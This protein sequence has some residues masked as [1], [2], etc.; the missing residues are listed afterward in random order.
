[1]SPSIIRLGGDVQIDGSLTPAREGSTIKLEYSVQGDEWTP[2]AEARTNN[3]G[4]YSYLWDT[5]LT[6]PGKHEVRASW[7][8]DP[9][10]EGV[11]SIP[12]FF[13]VGEDST[14]S[15]WLSSVST[16]VNS[17]LVV[18]GSL[19]P[20]HAYVNV[21]VSVKAPNGT[22][23][24]QNVQTDA[25]GNYKMR[26]MPDTV[27]E[28]SFNASWLGDFDTFGSGSSTTELV[29]TET[30][31]LVSLQANTTLIAIGE[32]IGFSGTVSPAQVNSTVIVTLTRP[33]SNLVSLETATNSDGT[34]S[35]TYTPDQA[36]VW[37]V[38]A[39]WPGTLSLGGATSPEILFAVDKLA[40]TISL[41]PNPPVPEKGDL[42]MFEGTL[43][44]NGSGTTV[45]I[46]ISDNDG[47]S[48]RSIA[49]TNTSVDSEYAI[50]WR[51][52]RI[53]AFMFKAEWQGDEE[54]YGCSSP[55]VTLVIQ[56]ETQRQSVTIPDNREVEVISSTDSPATRLTVDTVNG[57][58][59][60]IVN[61]TIGST[62]LA[63][64]FVPSELL[65]SYEKTVHDLVFAVDGTPVVP[66]IVEVDG[67]YLVTV[68]YSRSARS[69]SLYYLTYTLTV[70]VTDYRS[71]ALA[72]AD[73]SLTGP[74]KIS[75]TSNSSGVAYFTHL[76]R[77]DYGV[78]IYYGPLVGEK[79]VNVTDDTVSSISTIFAKIGADYA[80]LED[81][82]QSLAAEL[83]LIRTSTYLSVVA[84]MVFVALVSFSG[85]RTLR[86][87]SR[88]KS[89][90][91]RIGTSKT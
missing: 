11:V 78:R 76:P 33:D 43:S 23:L 37:L 52:D 45:S 41:S 77:G 73:V 87:F 1:V 35:L 42:V 61:G 53:G 21:T 30:G 64:V 86:I 38:Q 28:W 60:A 74:V 14:L 8:G 49:S 67:G 32:S 88:G 26:F 20:L 34:F 72:G 22:V 91:K 29:V 83:N 2:I 10:H 51:A 31:S 46:L 75:G 4:G 66:D 79:S 25:A 5:T 58:I 63:N 84:A 89:I 56:D 9:S 12:S 80:E 70:V 36:G 90:L 40:S 59:E 3:N 44:M 62:G 27:G 69:L 48:W 19:L 16:S 18:R 17:L 55:I 6:S 50:P 85:R 82:Y 47:R 57:K 65:D 54:H 81:R 71:E 13:Y 68:W 7:E 15:L 24:R 39:S